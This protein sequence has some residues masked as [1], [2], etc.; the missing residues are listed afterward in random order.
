MFHRLSWCVLVGVLILSGS[1]NASA[2]DPGP[3][4]S[5]DHDEERASDLPIVVEGAKEIL[6][7]GL[8]AGYRPESVPAAMTENFEGAW[9][10]TGWQ[11]SDQSSTDDGEYLMGKR[12]CHPRTG[13]YAG[14]MTGGG[15]KG[16]TL[17]CSGKYSPNS[18][19]WAIYGPFDLSGELA[20]SLTFHVW[21]RNEVGEPGTSCSWDYLFAGSS[22]DGSTFTGTRYC[23]TFQ[24]GTDGNGYYRY[25]IDLSTQR[26][27]SQVWVAFAFKSNDSAVFSDDVGITVDDI[28][29]GPYTPLTPVFDPP[30]DVSNHPEMINTQPG[31]VRDQ[32]GHIHIAYMGTH[33]QAGAPD[34]VAT[35]IFYTNNVGGSFSAPVQINVPT[36]YYSYRPS[37]VVDTSDVVHIA[38]SRQM[39]QNY[40][41][42]DDDIWCVN[43]SGGSFANPHRIV[44]GVA[45]GAIEQPREPMINVD[46][47]GVA[48]VAFLGWTPDTPALTDR[49]LYMH[50]GSGAFGT[51]IDV[52]LPLYDVDDFV[53]VLDGRGWPHFAIQAVPNDIGDDSQVFYVKSTNDPLVAAAF[54][55][56]LNVSNWPRTVGGWWAALAV[57]SDYH[58]HIAFRD[59]FG[60]CIIGVAE[61][62]GLY[63]VSNAA[64]VFSAPVRITD[65]GA[66]APWLEFDANGILHAIYKY[67]G[68]QMAY[69]NN[70][71][72]GFDNALDVGVSN[73]V[74]FYVPR[75]VAVGPTNNIHAT[76]AHY[77]T[78]QIHYIHGRYPP[79]PAQASA[80][81]SGNNV[82]L[83][84]DYRSN[85][86]KYEVHRGTTPYFMPDLLTRIQTL[87]GSTTTYTDV[88]AL[89]DPDVTHYYSVVAVQQ[90]VGNKS[91]PVGEFEFRLVNESHSYSWITLTAQDFEGAFPSD[92]Q[93]FDDDGTQNGEYMWAKRNC[94]AYAGS[95]SGWAIGGGANGN[96][97]AC[98]ANY[99]SSTKSWM[100][101]GP[102]SLADATASDLKFKLWLNSESNYDKLFWGASI[103]GFNFNGYV[104]SGNSSGWVDRSLDLADVPTLGNLLGRS[105]V[106]VALSF[107]SDISVNKAEGAY[108]DDIVLRKYAAA[109]AHSSTASQSI[110][111]GFPAVPSQIIRVS[112]PSD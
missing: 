50:N 111:V 104:S 94:Q 1:W 9:P 29:L 101:Y 66:F 80:S 54:T 65:C 8:V 28:T 43:N 60:Q 81:R 6:P 49:V 26:G 71:S 57:D 76:Y 41:D 109:A 16:S 40:P 63:Y 39:D 36:G 110:N 11:L 86:E 35:D 32:H 108:V 25:T 107:T 37:I 56:P 70:M 45:G 92:W 105:S 84:W 22:L 98:G 27:Q 59:V 77:G 47:R 88:G 15:A 18:D 12:N 100:V 62:A 44:D 99:A 30:V 51:P 7:A 91:N 103:D 21:G 61:E 85:I 14:W 55:A 69:N 102:F 106:W 2:V 5:A 96:A 97:L 38:F 48:H 83:S 34:D 19:T 20:A 52:S 31:L 10:A 87:P 82:M 23:G 58:A 95:Y 67:L 53:M 79:L 42:R 90:G 3:V 78:D 17:A 75:H 24:S 46:A 4:T 74:N 68:T 72:G 112:T 64:G 93:V 13:S 89:G 73:E 33:Y